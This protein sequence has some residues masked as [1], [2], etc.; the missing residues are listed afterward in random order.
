MR[1]RD[2]SG[3]ESDLDIYAPVLWSNLSA[4]ERES[5][6]KELH[7]LPTRDGVNEFNR[8]R[9]AAMNKPV[10]RCHAKHNSPSAA[11][12]TEDDAEGLPTRM[13]LAEGASVMITR[14]LWTSRGLVN[15]A[16]DTVEK[17]VFE[18][19]ANPLIDPPAV[20]F[21][22]VPGY[23]GPVEARW[24]NEVY[25][26]EPVVPIAPHTVEW[27]K[28]GVKLTRT[29]FPLLLAF[30][31]TI[32]KSQ[33]LTLE[34]AVIDPGKGATPGLT[35]VAISRVKSLKGLAL[36]AP[37]TMKHIS[38]SVNVV[39]NPPPFPFMLNSYGQ[40]LS[41]YNFNAA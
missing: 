28:G 31:I 19:G 21:V 32:H 17:I 10:V 6:E 14:N 15:G 1:F 5:F 22:R 37:L 23:V 12:G 4:A 30:A 26:R 3:L 7:L 9:L 25:P 11:K 29:Q 27:E 40:D 13:F 24:Q 38:N 39:G 2:Y 20:I 41:R 35:F 33:G 34:R 16:R 36:R 8:H 18:P